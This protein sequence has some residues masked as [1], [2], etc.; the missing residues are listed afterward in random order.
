M[1]TKLSIKNFNV[2]GLENNQSKDYTNINID[3]KI[4]DLIEN[5]ANEWKLDSSQIGKIF[6]LI[7]FEFL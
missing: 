6:T 5:I 3:V 2:S 4:S 1:S 7:L